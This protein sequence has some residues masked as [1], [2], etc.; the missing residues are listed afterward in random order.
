MY[1]CLNKYIN[2]DREVLVQLRQTRALSQEG[3]SWACLDRGL[4]LSMAT[5]KRAEA[6]RAILYRSAKSF[7]AY[8]GCKLSELTT[9]GLTENEDTNCNSADVFVP[10]E[11]PAGKLRGRDFELQLFKQVLLRCIEEKTGRLLCVRGVAG[12]GKSK[13][14]EAFC[15]IGRDAS[16]PTY[17]VNIEQDR[18]DNRAF[19]S[20]LEQVFSDAQIDSVNELFDF[21]CETSKLDSTEQVYL[22]HLLDIVPPNLN[23]SGKV[24]RSS[25]YGSVKLFIELLR[26]R[27]HEKNIVIFFEDIHWAS[28]ELLMALKGLSAEIYDTPILMVISTRLENDPVDTIWRSGLLNTPMNTIDLAPLSRSDTMA[29]ALEYK[30][31]DQDYLDKILRLADGNPL[32]LEQLL[33]NYPDK[34][35]CLPE[36]IQDLIKTRLSTLDEDS[37]RL[38]KVASVIGDQVDVDLLEYLLQVNEMEF[39]RLIHSQIIRTLDEDSVHFSHSLIR[40]G[41]YESINDDEKRELH[42]QAAKWFY[43]KDK[44][45]HAQHLGLANSYKASRAFLVAAEEALDKHNFGAAL[46]LIDSALLKANSSQEKFQFISIKGM[47][48]NKL[49]LPEQALGWFSLALE[50]ADSAESLCEIH[51]SMASTY[52]LLHRDQEAKAHLDKAE[53][54]CHG[55]LRTRLLYL[56]SRANESSKQA[57]VGLIGHCEEQYDQRQIKDFLQTFDCFEQRIVEQPGPIRSIKVGVLHSQT[58][59][60]RELEC[61]VIRTTLIAIGEINANGGL[62]GYQLEPVLVDGQSNEIGFYRGAEKLLDDADVAAVFGSSTSSSRRYIRHLFEDRNRLLVYPFQYEGI[63]QSDNVFYIGPAPNQTALPAVE[64][65]FSQNKRRLMLVGS[66]YVYPVVINSLIKQQMEEWQLQAPAEVYKP[67]GCTQYGNIIENIKQYAPDAIVLTLVG[68]QANKSFFQQLHDSGVKAGDIEIVSLVL[69]ENDLSAIPTEHVKGTYSLFAYF[70]NFEDPV[71]AQFVRRY[72]ASYGIEQQIGGYM[73]S[74]YMG[75]YL[76]AKAVQKAGLFDTDK[77]RV[78]M[79]GTAHY[80]PGGIAYI[81]EH[82]N[83]TWRHVQLA[84]VNSTGEFEI[85]WRSDKPV[86]PEPFP[87]GERDQWENRLQQLKQS[88]WNNEWE[89]LCSGQ[90][91]KLC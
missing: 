32:F 65:L 81:D 11:K 71:N 42:C 62:L 2:L 68:L 90:Q 25:C 51:L 28:D 21:L 83:H 52:I 44:R 10:K 61:G 20:L 54:Q 56:R 33:L 86:R 72:K 34:I 27:H 78:A 23:V 19:S 12:I 82:N 63:E 85:V 76:W 14:L 75:V 77:V 55:D 73:E 79:R 22:S 37:L 45:L 49:G 47:I 80:G 48:F 18:G 15:E 50:L 67:L 58:G 26:A 46:S 3:L 40:Q 74:A 41:I 59:P 1:L 5:I 35:G 7:A 66:D 9:S 60:L 64:W 89:L 88:R 6:G 91:C 87:N 53:S 31:I 38:A 70:Q 84:R 39:D 17:S 57:T 43:G 13:L 4:P 36:T 16:C 24:V 30:D 69:S 8:Y 29:M